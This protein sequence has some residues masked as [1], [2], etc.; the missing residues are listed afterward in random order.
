VN[1]RR[2]LLTILLVLGIVP[3]ATHAQKNIVTVAGGG[4]NNV[5]AL[6]ASIGLPE[7]VAQD[8]NLNLYIADTH[9]NNVYMINTSGQLTIFAGNGTAGFSGD[10][11]LAT[12]AQLSGPTGIFVD[13]NNN[14][15]IADSGNH[16]IREVAATTLIITTVAGTGGASGFSGDGGAATSAK[17]NNPTGVFV[18][19]SND[20]F[21]ADSG[22]NVIREVVGTTIS[23]IA[24]TPP[25]ALGGFAGNGGLATAAVLH[26]PLSVSLDSNGNIYI[27]DQG[28]NEIREIVKA[29]GN[30]Q[31]FV[32]SPTGAA[33]AT[34]DGGLATLALLHGPS[35]VFVDANNNVFIADT[36]NSEIREVT[37]V[38]G[39]IQ[40]IAGIG[41][42]GFSGDGGP[43]TSAAL[44]SPLGLFVDATGNVVI[45][46]T[47]NHFVRQVV[48]ASKNIHEIAGNGQLSFSGDGAIALNA[49]LNL[50]S[51]VA[52]DGPRD[53]F[54]AD[55]ANNAVREVVAATGLT[56]TVA[57]T[58]GGAL[59]SPTGVFVD[60][61]N[62]VYIADTRNNVIREIF[63]ATGTV[64]IIVGTGTAGSSGDGGPAAQ[65]QL[66]LPTGVYVDSAGDI[67]I[68]DMGNNLIREVVFATGKIQTVAGINAPPNGGTAGFG[69]DGGLATSAL[70]SAPSGVFL[71]AHGNI[72]IADTGNN[73]IREVTISNQ[74]IQTVAGNHTLGAGFSGD[75]G[76]A[77]AAQLN[78]P[79]SVIVDPSGDFFIADTKNNVIR[80]VTAGTGIIQTVAGNHALGAGFSGDGGLATSAALHSPSSI[81]I[82]S[83]GAVDIADT[84]NNRIRNAAGLVTVPTVVLAPP[85]LV[86]NPT[87]IGRNSAS[88]TVTLTN[89]GSAPLQVAGISF[90]GANANSFSQTNNC[91]AT[92]PAAPSTANNCSINV[93]FTPTTGGTL[94]AS[95]SV[96]DSAPGSPQLTT[97]S[98]TGVS[99]VTLLPAGLSFPIQINTTSSAPQ[100]ITLTNN[101]TV[102]LNITG[103][104]L[105]GSN[106]ASF[107]QV[108]TC[109]TAVTAGSSCVITVT[110]TPNTTGSNSAIVSIADDAPGSP[111]TGTL[112]GLGTG[113][114]ATLTP[115]SLTFG[116]QAVTTTSTAQVVTVT[117]KG[118]ETLNISS[119]IFTG[120]NNGDFSQTTTCGPTVL[121]G[122]N[123]TISVTF[124][125]T[126][127]GSRTASLTLNDSAGDSPQSINL[128]ATG[129]DFQIVIP[130][131]GSASQTVTAGISALFA[132]EVDAV[133]GAA[134]TDTI[135]VNLTCPSA[136]ALP[137]G[138]NCVLPQSSVTV[139]PGTSAN[140]SFNV[141]TT[142]KTA[143]TAPNLWPNFG[144]PLGRRML[145]F[146]AIALLVLLGLYRWTQT[147]ADELRVRPRRWASAILLVTILIGSAG[148]LSGCG[149]G[150][151]APITG[152]AGSTV[153]GTYNISINGTAGNDTH[154]I[155]V[156]L[157]VQ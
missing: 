29:T 36:T 113:A 84:G 128:F 34:G 129:I 24:G 74:Q 141:G 33:G 91:P 99:A 28:N 88:Q 27:A 106:A 155:L 107:S 114:T 109:G 152:A 77:T 126:A 78:G 112:F 110:F 54:I 21:I 127:G 153:P 57:G 139:S 119:I 97:L 19:A 116:T 79:L 32:G 41:I 7:G 30:I 5:A 65:A 156:T 146:Y 68:A 120:A 40:R 137:Q 111:Q 9:G 58:T 50:P 150:G 73:V 62:N 44:S 144:S 12:A 86:F 103:I 75:T 145:L 82:D 132:I 135:T 149:N 35:A 147:H 98:G 63:A 131:G 1:V 18:D 49:A 13:A 124:M 83:L 140:V 94:G 134:K 118:K 3:V 93:T 85:S 6:S 148:F 23:T 11:G 81:A 115:S 51:G 48:E 130:A 133:G 26:N 142:A 25:P 4:P 69:G 59:N 101:Q 92:L 16:V 80:E 89:T 15:F 46:D 22:N 52:V 31:N 72:F 20:I 47:T 108:N 64:Q 157:I 42:P 60:S 104:T 138:T 37:S 61:S 17:L 117:N 38:N 8:S 14:V 100:S 151:P 122:A 143:F 71:D 53:I 90:T 87:V 102:T 56:Q 105:S 125:P 10:T 76:L 55:T 121:P 123:C 154:S 95:L 66:R 43:A 96:S 39:N 2:K 136:S 70:L 67:F 45:S